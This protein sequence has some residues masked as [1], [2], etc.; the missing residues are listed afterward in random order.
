MTSDHLHKDAGKQRFLIEKTVDSVKIK[1]EK[2]TT[3]GTGKNRIILGRIHFQSEADWKRQCLTGQDD[4]KLL[5]NGS[6]KSHIIRISPS[7]ARSFG[8]LFT[9]EEDESESGR[10]QILFFLT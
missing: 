4:V 3:K 8:N 6:V 2:G 10:L 9:E 1:V 5:K 7:N